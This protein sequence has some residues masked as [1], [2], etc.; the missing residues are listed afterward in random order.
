MV[1]PEEI[2]KMM[3]KTGTTI[4]GVTCSEGVVLAADT[5]ATTS[6]V[7]EKN[8]NKIHYIEPN[9]RCCGAGT[10]ADNEYFAK[11]ISAEMELMRR[12]TG[13]ETRIST[14]VCRA[15]SHLFRYGGNIGAY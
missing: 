13:R 8:C 10:A 7:A 9:I 15:S 5:R 2:K 4:V 12:N 11:K 6:Y 14:V 1:S 3:K